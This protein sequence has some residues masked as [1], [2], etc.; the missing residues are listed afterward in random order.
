MGF[1]GSGFSERMAPPS[2]AASWFDGPFGRDADEVL[3][4]SDLGDSF[5]LDAE[6]RERTDLLDFA[7]EPVS[8]R[9]RA[10]PFLDLDG[11]FPIAVV[12]LRRQKLH[13]PRDVRALRKNGKRAR[14]QVGG[15]A[16]Q[17][18][19]TW[20]VI[21]T[22]EASKPGRLGESGQRKSGKRNTGLLCDRRS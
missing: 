17:W 1:S 6:R 4:L 21:C 3:R 18:L 12:S 5:T 10:N 2:S 16:W 19:K 15:L 14:N 8:V 20:G 9:E 22:L 11:L 13:G 7:E